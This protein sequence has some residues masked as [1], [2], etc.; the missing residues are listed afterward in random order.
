[1]FHSKTIY[2]YLPYLI[3]FIIFLAILY[4]TPKSKIE[5]FTSESVKQELI[6]A[7]NQ[8]TPPT[9]TEYHK[10]LQ[11]HNHNNEKDL[12]MNKYI[13]LRQNSP[14]TLKNL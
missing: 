9:F 2:E 10:I 5:S 6:T 7:F 14:L 11:K 12:S 13:H 4:I 3:A 8:N 1:M